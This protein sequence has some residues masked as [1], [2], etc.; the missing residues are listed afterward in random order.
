MGY[1]DG[2]FDGRESQFQKGFDAGYEQGFQNG[3][4]LGKFKARQ[5]FN[6]TES[7]NATNSQNDLILQRSS[8]GQCVLCIDNALSNSSIDEIVQK[9]ANHMVKINDTLKSRYDAK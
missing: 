3:F 7:N 5:N 8:R 1:K 4:V 9:Q 6:S 2:M